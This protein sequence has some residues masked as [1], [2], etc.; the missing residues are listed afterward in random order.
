MLVDTY[1][2]EG[3]KVGQ[4]KLPSEIFDVKINPDLVYQVAVSQMANRR[5]TIAH[6][7]T[8]GEVSGGGKKPWRQKGTGR[9]RHG[10]TRSP[11]WRHGGVV[12]GPRKEKIFK[13]EIPKKM[14]RKALLMILS[15]KAKENFLILFDSLKIEKPKTK[16]MA[17][18]LK[19]LRSKIENFKK[20]SLLI[21]L[22]QKDEIIYRASRNIPDVGITEARN[23]NALDLLSCK[24]LLMSK[25][26]IKVIKEIFLK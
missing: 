3:Q 11:I 13:K 21:A 5:K 16:I 9:A 18:I 1:N 24:Y 8:R 17:Q 25:D 7:K 26:T 10:S 12:F 15:A 6:T 23:L 22:S 2:Q 4:T 19:N 20:G 14:R